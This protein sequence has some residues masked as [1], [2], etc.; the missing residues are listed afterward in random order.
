MIRVVFVCTGNTCRSP[1]AA[2]IARS[3]IPESWRDRVEFVSAGLSASEGAGAT[4]HAEEALRWKGL[5]LKG[6]RAARFSA[7]AA[8]GADLIVA[9]T[10]DHAARIAALAPETREK[11][12]VL[13]TLDPGRSD[14][15]V[16]D[17]IGGTGDVYAATRDELYGLVRRLFGHMKERFG[18]S[19]PG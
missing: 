6:H 13:G 11:L 2:E 18:A 1:M 12:I 3:M 4:L 15:D 16:S 14:P 8:A 17:P 7:A 9:M 5:S 19:L 10:L